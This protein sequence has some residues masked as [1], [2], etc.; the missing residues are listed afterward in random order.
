ML[1]AAE[2]NIYVPEGFV[3]SC[4]I[5]QRP[6]KSEVGRQFLVEAK[7]VAAKTQASA[8]CNEL[9]ETP[10]RTGESLGINDRAKERE[11]RVKELR[12]WDWL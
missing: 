2:A 7:G 11:V 6:G 5:F 8:Y 10:F 12:W 1:R 3:E 9:S 4:R